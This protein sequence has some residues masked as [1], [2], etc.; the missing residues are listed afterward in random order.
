MVA[1]QDSTAAPAW[2]RART[3]PS[4]TSMPRLAMVAVLDT[5]PDASADRAMA[6]RACNKRRPTCASDWITSS[7]SSKRTT[8]CGWSR[9]CH[10]GRSGT[11]GATS[12]SK[13]ASTRPLRTSA[14]CSQSRANR[15]KP[16]RAASKPVTTTARPAANAGLCMHNTPIR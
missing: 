13:A 7:T 1:T 6:W 10:N 12:S 3:R 9:P 4:R 5:K 16:L 11:R 8:A 2:S 14:G 15:C